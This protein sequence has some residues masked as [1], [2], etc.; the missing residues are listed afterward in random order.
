MKVLIQKGKR[1]RTE[2]GYVLNEK[3][4]YVSLCE[5]F[6]VSVED[7]GCASDKVTYEDKKHL[8]TVPFKKH[9][10]PDNE[11]TI[12]GYCG[13]FYELSEDSTKMCCKECK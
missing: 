5:T 7:G 12:C 6:K 9:I 4:Q 3:P 1:R 13:G 10:H 8:V 11:G 2:H